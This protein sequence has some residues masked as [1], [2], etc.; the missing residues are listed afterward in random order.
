VRDV[1]AVPHYV[2]DV[3]G[4]V[5]P[6]AAHVAHVAGLQ[7]PLLVWKSKESRQSILTPAGA[8]YTKPPE[9]TASYSHCWI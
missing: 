6:D 4:G 8:E 3:G 2:Q 7:D 5:G 1:E 9:K